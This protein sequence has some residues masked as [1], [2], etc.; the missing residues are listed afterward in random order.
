MSE[1]IIAQARQMGK[2]NLLWNNYFTD[3]ISLTQ[4]PVSIWNHPKG[5]LL[6]TYERQQLHL[7]NEKVKA[8][9]IETARKKAAKRQRKLNRK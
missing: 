4:Y 5:R 1:N 8:R 3:E 7:K 9:K 6:T 2:T